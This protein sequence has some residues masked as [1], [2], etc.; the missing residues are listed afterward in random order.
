[1]INQFIDT[2][3]SKGAEALLPQN[4]SSDWLE[5]LSIAARN[6]ICDITN[7][8][9]EELE[10]H[11]DIFESDESSLLLISVTEI[12]QFQKNYPAD[13]NATDLPEDEIIGYLKCYSMSVI[14]EYIKRHTNMMFSSPGIEN[15][16]DEF[17]LIAIEENHPELTDA[18]YDF[19]IKGE[20]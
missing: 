11:V 18:L 16:F 8:E 6:F 15:I 13:F 5:R 12:I 17:R 7:D 3:V 10:D 2:I 19:V 14:Y 20:L 9:N 1:M 4:L